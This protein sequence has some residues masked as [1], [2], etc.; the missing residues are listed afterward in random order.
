MNLKEAAIIFVDLH[1]EDAI[2]VPWIEDNYGSVEQYLQVEGS[3]DE[4]CHWTARY[5]EISQYDH[6]N[7]HAQRI[8]WTDDWD[9]VLPYE[10]SGLDDWFNVDVSYSD[11][12][13]KILYATFLLRVE[14]LILKECPTANVDIAGPG[15]QTAGSKDDEVER[16]WEL[17]AE[18]AGDWIIPPG[19]ANNWVCAPKAINQLR[20][21]DSRNSFLT[22]CV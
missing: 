3:T 11:D 4:Y 16:I 19:D 17:V 2:D 5:I 7:G 12:E 8:D 14:E 22:R 6:V 9:I 18:E 1:A 10:Q 21:S 15:D 20:M 13:M